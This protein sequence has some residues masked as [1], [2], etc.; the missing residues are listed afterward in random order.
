MLR[1]LSA[2]ALLALAACGDT[3]VDHR[4]TDLLKP[5]GSGLVCDP[6]ACEDPNPLP[7]GAKRACLGPPGEQT[8]GYECEGGLL[9]CSGGCCTATQVA[10]GKAHTCAVTGVPI[11]DELFCWGANEAGQSAPGVISNVFTRPWRVR[12]SVTDVALGDVHTCAIAG[13]AVSC[14]GANTAGQTIVPALSNAVALAAGATF[15]CA[16]EAGGAVKCWGGGMPG[17]PVAS[18]ATAI[19]AGAG[20]AC[21]LV[22]GAVRCWGAGAVG[23]LGAA[24]AV[25]FASVPVEPGP[26]PPAPT[27]EIAAVAAGAN[28]TC[29]A[30]QTPTGGAIDNA[31]ACWGSGLGAPLLGSDPAL[32]PA[33]PMKDA[34]QSVVRF[35]VAALGVGRAHVC[36]KRRDPVVPQLVSC[37]GSE[38]GFGQLGGASF[39]GETVEVP[40]TLGAPA[41]AIGSDHGCAIT[42]TGPLAGGILCWGRNASGQLGDG[43]QL[44]PGVDD[45]RP[46]GPVPVSGL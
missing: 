8:C 12:G 14:W 11:A 19:S 27:S 31:L 22:G 24:P 41:F 35:D 17:A 26:W 4:A 37:L 6:A 7:A 32:T 15:T 29:A 10:A 13:G 45:G 40:G 9:K 5:P 36:V 25:A 33:I 39:A 20:H 21:A 23:Q 44:T 3:L 1:R 42:G 30:T 18:G 16:L 2:A 38:N 28:L 34:N 43:T 46:M